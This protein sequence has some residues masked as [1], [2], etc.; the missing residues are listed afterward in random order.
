MFPL[1]ICLRKK[2]IDFLI[3]PNNDM[4]NNFYLGGKNKFLE[5]DFYRNKWNLNL[6]S[7]IE[8]FYYYYYYYF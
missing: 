2:G 4:V 7:M 3:I 5:Y 1:R 6:L 8:F